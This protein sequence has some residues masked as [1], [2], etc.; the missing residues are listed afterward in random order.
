MLRVEWEEV[1]GIED[2]IG[3][4]V[5]VYGTFVVTKGEGGGL[6]RTRTSGRFFF[7]K[8]AVCMWCI[9]L[10]TKYISQMG[11]GTVAKMNPIRWNDRRGRRRQN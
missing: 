10:S 8:V 11:S 5:G 7:S 2:W 4:M 6:F 3:Y 1:R 9:A